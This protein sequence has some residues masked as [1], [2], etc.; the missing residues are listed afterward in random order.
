MILQLAFESAGDGPL[1]GVALKELARAHSGCLEPV[2]G[3]FT[4]LAGGQSGFPPS[5]PVRQIGNYHVF[6]T[7]FCWAVCFLVSTT[8]RAEEISC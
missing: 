3:R 2:E 1:G 4:P 8:G 7:I 5:V 6:A